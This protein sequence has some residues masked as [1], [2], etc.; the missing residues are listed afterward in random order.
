MKSKHA[1]MTL[2]SF[3]ILL[4]VVG[5]FAYMAMKLVPAYTEFMGVQKAMNDM[6][7]ENFEGK[8]P[9]QIRNDLIKKMDYQYVSDGTITPDDITIA[10]GEQ[11][12]QLQVA[13]DKDIPFI[14]NIDFL[15]HFEKSVPIQGNVAASQ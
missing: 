10:K 9:L 12:L 11:G 6:A 8:T 14:S 15:V 3:L 2:I 5:F 7:T 1:G 4:L 13:Y